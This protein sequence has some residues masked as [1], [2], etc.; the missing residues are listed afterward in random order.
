[1]SYKSLFICGYCNKD[2]RETD[3]DIEKVRL[4]GYA[5]ML[6]RT[7]RM[8]LEDEVVNIAKRYLNKTED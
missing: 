3:K 7:C 8:C 5:N 1:M 6:C 4:A 2:T